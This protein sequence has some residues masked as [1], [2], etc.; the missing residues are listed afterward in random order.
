MVRKIKTSKK[1]SVRPSDYD[2]YHLKILEEPRESEFVNKNTG[3]VVG[4]IVVIVAILFLAFLFFYNPFGGVKGVGSNSGC[5]PQCSK[6]D[7][8]CQLVGI[9]LQ[10]ICVFDNQL[11]S[12]FK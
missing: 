9:S 3:K 4:I 10:T 1:G 11:T 7:I 6:T 12:I 2:G 8:A 5:V